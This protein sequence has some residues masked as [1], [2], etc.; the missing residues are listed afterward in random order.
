VHDEVGAELER[1]LE[2]GSREGVVDDAERADLVG[3]GGGGFDVDDPEQ[4]IRRRLD[5]DELRPIVERPG[6]K[7][8]R[9]RPLDLV[10]LRLVDLREETVGAAVDVVDR[11][12]PVAGREEVEDGG[13]RPHP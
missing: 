1:P 13:G 8:V 10:A 6:Q 7:R 11:D 4:R 3:R 9:R 12:D 5:P 2:K